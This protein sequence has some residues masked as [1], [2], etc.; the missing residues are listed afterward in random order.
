M[1]I[2]SS[3]SKRIVVGWHRMQDENSR[4]QFEIVISTPPVF[5]VEWEVRELGPNDLDAV[6]LICREAFPLEY[7]DSWFKEVCSGCFISFGLFHFGV[8]VG[9]LVAELK[10]L[11]NCDAEVR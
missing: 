6:C 2:C 4:G 1:D 11:T 7:S 3:N 5:K 8:L 9:L 10:L